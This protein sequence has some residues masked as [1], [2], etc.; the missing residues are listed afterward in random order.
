MRAFVKGAGPAVIGRASSALANGKSVPWGDE[1]NARAAQE[2]ERLGG[3]G[4]RVMVAATRDIDPAQFDPD[5]DLLSLMTDLQMTA[6]V[7]MIDPPQSRVQGRCQKRSERK[8]P[9]ADGDRRRHRHRRCDRKA[10][11]HPR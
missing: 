5:G 4:L 9:G 2:M 3:K 1:Q 11:R 10:A 6:M 7:G 8:H